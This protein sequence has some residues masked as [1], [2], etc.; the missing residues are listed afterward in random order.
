MS[1]PAAVR[2]VVLAFTAVLLVPA[3]APA[4]TPKVVEPGGIPARPAPGGDATFLPFG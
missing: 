1:A 2:A 3:L 4:A